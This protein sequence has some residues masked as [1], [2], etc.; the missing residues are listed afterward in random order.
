[1][2]STPY[3]LLAIPPMI[4]A[5]ASQQP[6][7]VASAAIPPSSIAAEQL[8]GDWGLASYH[9]ESERVRTEA[10]AR[11]QCNNP[12]RIGKGPTGGVMMY[13]ADNSNLSE[14]RLKGGPD[15]KNYIG[16]NGPIG[17]EDREI[18]SF[19]GN[20]MVTRWLDKDNASRYGTMIFVR[21]QRSSS[22]SVR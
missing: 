19:D 2:R 16:P 5:C 10:E 1:M 22:S 8:V 3:I 18:V 12:Y 13:L 9:Q 17:E 11:K 15:G 6:P 14:L 4:T 7:Q 21:C 20:V